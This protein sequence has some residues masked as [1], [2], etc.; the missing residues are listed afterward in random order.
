MAASVT[1]ALA[2]MLITGDYSDLIIA[3]GGKRYGVHRVVVCPQSP[4]ITAA[5]KGDFKEARSNTIEVM[6]SPTMLKCMLDYMYTGQYNLSPPRPASRPNSIDGVKEQSNLQPTTSIN[7]NLPQTPIT[8]SEFLIYHAR[9][10][11]TADYYGVT[12]LAQLAVSRIKNSLSAGKWSTEAFCDLLRDAAGSTGNQHFR[13]ALVEIAAAHVFELAG[14][15]IFAEG[16]IAHGLAA[17]VLQS[18]LPKLQESVDTQNQQHQAALQAEKKRADALEE[19]LRELTTVLS[20]TQG[21]K[22]TGCKQSFGC[23]I[24]GPGQNGGKR[25]AICCSKCGNGLLASAAN[26]ATVN[27]HAPAKNENVSDPF[28]DSFFKEYE[29]EQEY[30]P[31]P[32]SWTEGFPNM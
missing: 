10:N 16:G 13:Q 26:D 29:H 4:V 12:S 11:A 9:V 23:S 6:F 32:A 24:Q 8:Q 5:L 30:W 28:W 3:C 2:K 21:C 17:D 7:A 22:T 1:S 15:G 31:F 27:H 14:K 20:V 19:N 25:Y 18:S